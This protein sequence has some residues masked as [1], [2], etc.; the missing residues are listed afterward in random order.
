DDTNPL[1]KLRNKN[2]QKPISYEYYENGNITD[3]KSCSNNS[4]PY[5]IVFIQSGKN[6]GFAGGNNIGL[7][8]I[9]KENDFDYVWLL[10]PD[11]LIKSNTLSILI[12]YAD[13]LEKNVGIIGTALLYYDKPDTL[14]ALGGNFNPFLCTGKHIYGHQKY[15]NIDK[16][17]FDTSKIDM[18]IGAS[19]LIRKNVLNEVGLLSEEYFLY[20]EEIDYALKAKKYGFSLSLC[21]DAIVYHKEGSSINKENEN[22]AVS[23]FSDF[24]A[25][26]N[27]LIFTKKFYTYYLPSVIVGLLFSA[28][29][30]VERKEYVKAANIIKILFGKRNYK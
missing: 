28:L 8:Y 16:K 6:L 7:K 18:I 13:S 25:M 27:R 21:I 10:N 9:L 26:R 5:P 17:A 15:D 30:R 22:L 4:Y 19:M 1:N 14:Q 29:K 20:Y 2:I 12:D 11:T 3:Q 23:G 24:Y